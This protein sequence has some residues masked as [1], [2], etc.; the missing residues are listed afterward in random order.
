MISQRTQYLFSLLFFLS[1]VS[2]KNPVAAEEAEKNIVGKWILTYSSHSSDSLYINTGWIEFYA[3]DSFM[4]NNSVF[5]K[6]STSKNQS[7]HGLFDIE[8]FDLPIGSETTPSIRSY[9]L[10]LKVGKDSKSWDLTFDSQTMYWT[11]DNQNRYAYSWT[12]TN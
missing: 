7:L 4:S 1:F 9:A 3:D 8:A 5:W 10:I 11:P 2:C 6:D 12:K